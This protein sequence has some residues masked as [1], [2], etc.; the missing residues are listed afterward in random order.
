MFKKIGALMIALCL[1]CSC[2]L[3]ESLSFSGTVVSVRSE[4][5]IAPIGGTVKDI[6]A[7]NGQR[8][9]A[10]DAI[11]TLET[12]KVYALEDGV[13]HFFGEVGDSVE[14]VAEKYGAVAYIEPVDAY[15]L[16]ASTKTAYDARENKIVHPGESVYLRCHT[17][18]KHTGTGKVTQVS[19]NSFS[20]KVE[21]GDFETGEQVNVY[22]S[23]DCAA[24]SRIGRGSI[25][26]RDPAAYT[27]EGSIVSFC[28]EDGA[29]VRKGQVLF[30]T[31]DGSFDGLK[32]TGSCIT[33][34]SDGIVSAVSTAQGTAVTQGT[35]VAEIYPDAGRRIAVFAM[36]SDL[37]SLYPGQK[38]TVEFLYSTPANLTVEGTVESISFLADAENADE[39]SEES[40]YQVLIAFDTEED[41]R[42][43]MNALVT[44]RE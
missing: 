16:S 23:E 10:G 28:A 38:V 18:G 25:S 34:P 42:Y 43:G 1:L 2:A 21:S 3:A 36:E 15:T 41:I 26:R 40:C 39:E 14:T 27:G 31:L 22:R 5:V 8:V 32:M 17:D 33:V 4:A 9:Q 7:Q 13:V 24:A 29:A 44:T 30:E 6:A 20:V 19:G 11:I 35:Q 12:R 37:G